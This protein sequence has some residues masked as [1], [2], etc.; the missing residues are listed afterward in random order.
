MRIVFWQNYQN[1]LQSSLIRALA[2]LVP[3]VLLVTQ[4]DLPDWRRKCGWDIPNFGKTQLVVSPTQD[5]VSRILYEK[6]HESIH[7]FS[8]SR[9]DPLVW[10]AFQKCRATQA[11][12]GIYSEAYVW[13]DLKVALRLFRGWWDTFLYES[14][15]NFVLAIGEM[16]YRWFR[17]SGY[18]DHKLYQFG[19]FV[20]QPLNQESDTNH[21]K[22]SDGDSVEIVFIG[23]CIRRKGIDLL[24]QA[25]STLQYLNWKLQIIGDGE[26]KEA[27]EKLALQLG[28]SERV[29]FLGVLK[30]ADARFVMKNSD[31][32][33]L[34]S[35]WDGWGAVVNEALMEG[36][37]VVCSD[38][39]GSADLLGNLERGETFPAGSV[40]GL[41]DVL[42]KRITQG[43]RT[44]ELT[45]K[46]K[47]WSRNIR[48]EIAAD[49][50]LDVIEASI[51]G[52][53][54]PVTPWLKR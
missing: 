32:F 38:L 52:K 7:I 28:L 30:N 1:A 43:K 8:V 51:Y 13:N 31:L 37:P 46:I 17:M 12:I 16:G 44:A 53:P 35:R 45:N 47:E 34:P 39:C 25:L 4:E 27:F 9:V 49:Y 18:P 2:D 42:S 41:R 24:L 5:S 11:K 15:V 29:N 20:E 54:K 19:Y 50:L 14:S 3:T 10:Q 22:Q 26:R 6:Q 33:V 21:F 23:Q 36:V 40:T 48:G